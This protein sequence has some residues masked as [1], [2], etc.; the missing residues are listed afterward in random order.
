MTAVEKWLVG[1]NRW[2]YAVEAL[3][4]HIE[5]CLDF[6]GSPTEHKIGKGR[7]GE[8]RPIAYRVRRSRCKRFNPLQIL[9]FTA[10]SHLGEKGF[11]VGRKGAFWLM[12]DWS[13][14]Q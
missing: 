3:V 5:G 8:V 7:F 13:T 10:P 12:R 1:L 4:E 14:G 11:F 6:V 2:F 9:L